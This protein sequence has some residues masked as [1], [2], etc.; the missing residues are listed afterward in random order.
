MKYLEKNV[1]GLPVFELEG[2]IMG[3][4]ECEDLCQR[5][6]DVIAAG[7]SNLVVDFEKVQWMNSAGIGMLIQCVTRLRRDGGDLHFLGIHAKVGYYFRITKLDTVLKI[8]GNMNEVLKKL[9]LTNS[10]SKGLV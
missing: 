9:Q 6:M 8:Y 3:G 7:Q 1:D 2:K 10:N 5:M 4:T